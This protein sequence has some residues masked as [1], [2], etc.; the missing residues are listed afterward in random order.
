MP[1]KCVNKTGLCPKL[2]DSFIVSD[3]INYK[4]EVLKCNVAPIREMSKAAVKEIFGGP[5][6]EP[7]IY[8]DYDGSIFGQ[9]E[10]VLKGKYKPYRI[11][12]MEPKEEPISF[13]IL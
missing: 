1:V 8:E 10:D 6:V 5:H 3:S 9:M 7:T 11:E 13:E 2:T 4:Y 12:S